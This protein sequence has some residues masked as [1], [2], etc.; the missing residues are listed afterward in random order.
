MP[1]AQAVSTRTEEPEGASCDSL[2]QHVTVGGSSLVDGS[3][4]V[5]RTVDHSAPPPSACA[6]NHRLPSLSPSRPVPLGTLW[7]CFAGAERTERAA[8]ARRPPP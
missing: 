3:T 4:L 7:L 1:A 2:Q 6:A 8:R 5:G